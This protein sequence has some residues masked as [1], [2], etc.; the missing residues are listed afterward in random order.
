[1]PCYRQGYGSSVLLVHLLDEAP[2]MRFQAAGVCGTGM[3]PVPFDALGGG[4]QM[5]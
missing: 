3:E 2:R 4:F 1:M 5:T